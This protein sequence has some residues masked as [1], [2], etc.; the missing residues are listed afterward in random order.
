MQPHHAHTTHWSP[1]NDFPLTCL[2]SSRRDHHPDLASET[3]YGEVTQGKHLKLPHTRP[4]LPSPP[5]LT[6]SLFLKYSPSTL[7][8]SGHSRILPAHF[9]ALQPL[10]PSGFLS[11]PPVVMAEFVRAQIFGTTFEITSR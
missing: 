4:N 1:L 2:V 6:V 10:H 3:K 8:L 11:S 7:S 9:R 5:R